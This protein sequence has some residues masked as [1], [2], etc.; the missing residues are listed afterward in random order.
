MLF[1]KIF[2]DRVRLLREQHKLS[3][4]A[5]GALLNKRPSTLSDIEAGRT[6]TTLDGLADICKLFAVSSDWL[7]GVSDEPY[8]EPTLMKIETSL[9]DELNIFL[10]QDLTEKESS[11]SDEQNV[12]LLP[13]FKR[14]YQDSMSSLLSNKTYTDYQERKQHFS[15]SV[16]ADISY[17]LTVSLLHLNSLDKALIDLEFVKTCTYLVSRYLFSNDQLKSSYPNQS[18]AV[19][20]FDPQTP[21]FDISTPQIS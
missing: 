18:L 19:L 6:G 14:A 9:L 5:L 11:L 15:L 2:A 17:L 12:H 20:R 1:N 10:S 21:F 7:I 4:K 3:L 13:V 16:R 8:S